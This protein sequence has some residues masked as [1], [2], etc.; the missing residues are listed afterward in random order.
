[1]PYKDSAA[2][3]L[4]A[5][6]WYLKNRERRETERIARIASLSE[7]EKEERRVKRNEYM[8]NY[9]REHGRR[10]QPSYSDAERLHRAKSVQRWLESPRL[11]PSIAELVNKAEQ[12]YEVEKQREEYRVMYN[13]EKSKRRKALLKGNV[14]TQVKP[15]A[16]R[17]RYAEFDNCCAYCGKQHKA[18]DL[19][20]EHF[21]PI[22]KGGT[23]VLS[24][25]VPACKPCNSSKTDHDAE[26]WYERQEF[27][28]RKRWLKIIDVL[29]KRKVH[30]GQLSFV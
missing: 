3:K 28:S 16:I 26:A 5:R 17:S 9:K 24:N 8:R 10:D 11:S 21:V 23:H 2:K 22:S 12:R 13:R 27:Y 1:M 14:L 29:G 15:S 18:M 4:A 20:I 25:I 19:Q 7:Q 30:A 6:N